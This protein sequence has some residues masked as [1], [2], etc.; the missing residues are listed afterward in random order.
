MVPARH[1]RWPLFVT[2]CGIVLAGCWGDAF[3]DL[4]IVNQTSRSVRVVLS[5]VDRGVIEPCSQKTVSDTPFDP[6]ETQVAQV[7]ELD[8]TVVLTAG[9]RP[10]TQRT[11]HDWQATL[12]VPGGA[13]DCPYITVFATATPESIDKYLQ[14]I[15]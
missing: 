3:Y 4:A 7:E 1:F 13:G 15:K 12:V 9:L 2:L 10:K 5:G 11:G 14:P 6:R 8:G